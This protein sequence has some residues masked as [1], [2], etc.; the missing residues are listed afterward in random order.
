MGGGR[1]I[2]VVGDVH[3]SWN[4]SVDE[5][6]LRHINPD[7]VLF[8][9]DF[10]NEDV[11]LVEEVSKLDM[12]K[13]VILG[14]HDCWYSGR[15]ASKTSSAVLQQHRLLGESHVGFKRLEFP[16]LKISVVGSRP[17]SMGGPRKAFFGFPYCK[18]MYGIHSLEESATKISE[19]AL[20]APKEHAIIVLGHNGPTGLGSSPDDI[21]GRDFDPGAGDHGDPDLE[22]ALKSCEGKCEIPLVVFGH[23]HKELLCGGE[24][25]MTAVGSNGTVYVNGA[26]VPRERSKSSERAFTVVTLADDNRV[27]KVTETW[28]RIKGKQVDT[29]AESVLFPLDE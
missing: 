7:L 8:T 17:F 21:C 25:K 13:A 20:G 22:E 27:D 1:V 9:G 16:G 4:S 10:G 24:R 26:V 14:N 28:V 29:V 18:E 12:A 23:M 6:A 19:L 5:Q 2:A 15:Y 11:E 3:G